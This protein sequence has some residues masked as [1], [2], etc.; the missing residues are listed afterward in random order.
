MI[1]ALI[2]EPFMRKRPSILEDES[3]ASF[4]GRRLSPELVDRLV[5]AG[6]HGIYAGN[7]YELS[8]KSL[9]K[10]IWLGERKHGSIIKALL[11]KSNKEA[12]EKTRN[13]LISELDSISPISKSLEDQAKK[14][15]V[16]T[17]RDGLGQFTDALCRHIRRD[18][19]VCIN[20]DTVIKS[21]SKSNDKTLSI[22]MSS[23][24]SE[25]RQQ[26]TKAAHSHVIWTAKPD[27]LRE[28]LPN[29]TSVSGSTTNIPYTT[30]MTV[31][32]YYKSPN[33]HPPGFG[34]LI[35]LAVTA[36][37]NPECALGVVFDTS[38]SPSADLADGSNFHG[39]VQDTVSKRGTKL[40]VMLGGHHWQ[41][42][43]QFPSFSDGEEMA[44]NLLKR[45]LN[46]TEKPLKVAVNLQTSCIPQYVVGHQKRLDNIHRWL[47]DEYSGQ[48]R[49]AGNWINGVG[50]NDCLKSA[51]DTV[52]GL[53]KDNL[54]GIEEALIDD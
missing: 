22:D 42:L 10:R 29:S 54:T 35:P 28:I 44:R 50:V 41:N 3:V 51:Y 5:S 8:A 32:I 13:Q 39:P 36:E 31:T 53:D 43:T 12:S 21:I 47:L 52:K 25:S 27:L 26:P 37:Q 14:S 7:V 4:L 33:L 9:M 16:F 38:Y 11:S 23:V 17:F 20:T 34:Y 45:H 2:T 46:I 30:V 6:F 24:Q 18:D 49:V 19:R 40:T 15:S 1:S 48:L